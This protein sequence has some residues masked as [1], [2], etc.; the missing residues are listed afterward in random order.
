VFSFRALEDSEA[1]SYEY[2]ALVGY[3]LRGRI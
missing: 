2:L 3:W 1:A